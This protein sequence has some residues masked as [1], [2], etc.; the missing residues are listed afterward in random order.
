[1]TGIT[2]DMVDDG[3]PFRQ[4]LWEH[5]RWLASHMNGYNEP[6]GEQVYTVM[7]VTCGHWDL[8]TCLP[9]QLE[10]IGMSPSEVPNVYHRW[11][12]IK[13][14]FAQLP[15]F[16]EGGG[17]K[18]MLAEECIPLIGHHHSGIDDSRNI[19]NLLL[20]L[21]RSGALPERDVVER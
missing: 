3:V 13:Q 10:L 2:Q 9:K 6:D 8:G 15:P 21:I 17:M 12:N 1:M 19:C 18:G 20:H 14:T 7:I 16:K 11:V 5:F 4:A